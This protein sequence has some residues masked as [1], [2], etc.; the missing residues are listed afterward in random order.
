ME[1]QVAGLILPDIWCRADE[2][3]TRCS[4]FVGQAHQI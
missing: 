4:G 2:I 3:N 1:E